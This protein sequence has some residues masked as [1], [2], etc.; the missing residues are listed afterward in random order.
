MRLH[1]APTPVNDPADAPTLLE[2]IARGDADAVRLLLDRYGVILRS[3][4]RR[5]FEASLAEDVVQEVFLSLWK[6][7]ARFDPSRASEAGFVVTVAKRRI[8]DLRRRR[9]SRP[10]SELDEAL[11]VPDEPAPDRVEQGD[12]FAAAMAAIEALKPAARE[13]LRMAVIEGLTHEEIST[14]TQLPLGT[15]KS[16]VRRGLERVRAAVGAAP[17][18]GGGA[19]APPPGGPEVRPRSS[20]SKRDDDG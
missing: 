2:R 10:E 8:V 4:A 1:A 19:R 20:P 11:D 6:S 18:A 14:T 5:S 17:R 9:A 12:D 13:V 15:V 7:A 16:H 3:M